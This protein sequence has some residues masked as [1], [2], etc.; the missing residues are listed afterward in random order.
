[1]YLS[2]AVM[3]FLQYLRSERGC[4]PDTLRTYGPALNRF[5]AWLQSE[6]LDDPDV[7]SIDVR[8]CR[9]YMYQMDSE[10]LRPRTRRGYFIP[11][12]GLYDMLMEHGALDANPFKEVKLPKRDAPG[13]RLVSEVECRGLWEAAGRLRDPVQAA[14]ARAFFACMLFCGLR[15]K[16]LLDLKIGDVVASEAI[17]RVRRGK[18]EKPRTLF[19]C[20][21]ALEALAQWLQLRPPSSHD[22]LW[23]LDRGRRIG[24][25]AMKRLME[26]IAAIAGYSGNPN[27]T[28]HAL[29]HAA[30]T[31]LLHHG[32]DLESIRDFLGHSQLQTT[33]I[34]LH[35]ERAHLRNV[36]ALVGFRDREPE[37]PAAPPTAGPWRLRRHPARP[38]K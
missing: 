14:Q 3:E 18:G 19:L 35:S 28:C 26:T 24:E 15:R 31:R 5:R 6:G 25:A 27:V 2:D 16:E 36:T 20:P 11:L 23:T 10:G 9:R 1:M 17:L 4:S 29:R 22:Y 33:A 30:A 8:L 7:K 12:R 13:Q 21:V 38:R 34:Y 32:A 37:P